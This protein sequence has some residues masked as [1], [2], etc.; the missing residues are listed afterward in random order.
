MIENFILFRLRWSR[1]FHVWAI[2]SWHVLWW[3]HKGMSYIVKNHSESPRGKCSHRSIM[4]H[5]QRVP[6]SLS[7]HHLCLTSH[8]LNV[9]GWRWGFKL[10]AFTSGEVCHTIYMLESFRSFNWFRLLRSVWASRTM[11]ARLESLESRARK[12]FKIQE[13]KLQRFNGVME[14]IQSIYVMKHD[15]QSSHD[16]PGVV[17]IST[18]K[19]V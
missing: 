14:K 8:A 5:F 13:E 15:T 19:H 17:Y 3:N 2:T 9:S 10:W 16:F 18:F 4:F 7:F 12:I 1:K 11:F 6:R